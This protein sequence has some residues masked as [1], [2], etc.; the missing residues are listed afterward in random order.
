MISFVRR[1]EMLYS[2]AVS[3][4]VPNGVAMITG[5]RIFSA[6]IL[7]PRDYPFKMKLP[8]HPFESSQLDN[9]G[10]IEG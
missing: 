5:L 9:V 10:I 4:G 8:S 7:R 2:F 6:N 3:S 1:L